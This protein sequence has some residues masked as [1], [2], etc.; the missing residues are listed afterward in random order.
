MNNYINRE[1]AVQGVKELFTMGDSY[2][3][4]HSIIG[5][6]NGIAVSEEYKPKEKGKW[7]LRDVEDCVDY[8]IDKWQSVK[9]SVCLRQ[10]TTPYSYYFNNYNF[11]PNCGADMR[12]E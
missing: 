8:P 3:D 5:M 9:C 7:I 1:K 10:L 12:S 2:C 6:L 11:C 4:E